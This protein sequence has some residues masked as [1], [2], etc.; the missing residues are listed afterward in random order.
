MTYGNEH[1]FHDE[2]SNILY[3][4]C[5]RWIKLHPLDQV[6]FLLTFALE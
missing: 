3:C 4:L 5:V 1:L 2:A 6:E